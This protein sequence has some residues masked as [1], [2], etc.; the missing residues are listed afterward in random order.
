MNQKQSGLYFSGALNSVDFYLYPDF[1]H[2]LSSSFGAL[3]CAG[4]RPRREHADQV[5]FVIGR[6]PDVVDR[7]RLP[8]RQLGRLFDCGLVE[9]LTRQERFGFLCLQRRETDIRQSDSSSP[10]N[11]CVIQGNLNGDARRRIVADFPL[12]FQICASTRGRLRRNPYLLEYFVR[13]KSSR[14]QAGE[15][16]LDRYLSLPGWAEGDERRSERQHRGRV[17]VRGVAVSQI[18]ADGGLVS[19]QRVSND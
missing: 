11:P 5:T 15:K 16:A 3:E 19:H 12:K 8:G 18:P 7:L 10:A 13:L 17:V 9:R 2:R 14:E 4:K 1:C 6:S